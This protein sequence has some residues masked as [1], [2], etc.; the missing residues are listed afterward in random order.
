MKNPELHSRSWLNKPGWSPLSS[1]NRHPNDPNSGGPQITAWEAS[2]IRKGKRSF[3]PHNRTPMT[4]HH[5]SPPTAMAL[6]LWL[7]RVRLK[8]PPAGAG[9]WPPQPPMQNQHLNTT[10]DSRICSAFWPSGHKLT[11][12]TVKGLPTKLLMQQQA[13]LW[14][15]ASFSALT[16]SYH[17]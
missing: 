10:W 17:F 1:F 6:I 3:T 13:F 7:A 15:L 8:S 9:R 12:Q 11:Q 16:I 14:Q 5:Q 2:Q 4:Q